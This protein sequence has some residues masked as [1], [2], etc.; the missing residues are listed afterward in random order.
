MWVQSPVI[1]VDVNLLSTGIYWIS[2][3]HVSYMLAA[4]QEDV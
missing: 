3:L 1:I 2:K 4:F